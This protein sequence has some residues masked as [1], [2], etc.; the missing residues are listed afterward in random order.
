MAFINHSKHMRPFRV[1]VT[2]AI[3]PI[4]RQALKRMRFEQL[5]DCINLSEKYRYVY[6]NNPKTGCTTLK[7]A[8]VELEVRDTGQLLDLS[9]PRSIHG[10]SSPLRQHRPIWPAPTLSRLV[11]QGYTF[12]GFIRN[13][14]TR[15]LSC[16][17]DKIASNALDWPLIL[18][19][20]PGQ[21]HPESFTEFIYQIV[22][23]TDL[24][25]NPH[26]RPQVA[27][28]LFGQIPYTFIGRFE[29]FAEDYVRTFA[30]IGVVGDAVPELCH[31]NRSH[32]QGIEL[33]SFYDKELQSLLYQRYQVD[34]ETFG[35]AYALPT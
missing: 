1:A 21:K 34:F 18:R 19:D 13:P 33:S 28:L 2:K 23:Q 7:S 3:C 6:I 22:P 12:I 26:W 27:N 16:Y 20:L 4:T 9:D 32:R 35:Y 11:Q 14:Y 5:I 8:L 15:L 25:M 31:L 10:R 29:A 17:L 30:A 24:E